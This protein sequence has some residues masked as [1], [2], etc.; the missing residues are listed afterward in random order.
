MDARGSAAEEAP[1]GVATPSP[2]PQKNAATTC[3]TSQNVVVLSSPPPTQTGHQTPGSVPRIL[4]RNINGTCELSFLFHF[5]MFLLAH[6]INI[7]K[8]RKKISTHSLTENMRAY[9]PEKEFM[10]FFVE[11]VS[12]Q[13]VINPFLDQIQIIVSVWYVIS[14]ISNLK[15]AAKISSVLA[16]INNINF[17]NNFNFRLEI[18]YV[19]RSNLLNK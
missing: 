11:E 3:A 9:A 15:L 16:S 1:R 19:N 12:E 10:I 13:N 14:S 6:L 5:H 8:V 4:S 2:V 17:Q 7:I 18:H